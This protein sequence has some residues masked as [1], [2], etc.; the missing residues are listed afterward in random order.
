MSNENRG[1]Y[2]SLITK[3]KTVKPVKVRYYTRSDEKISFIDKKK[4]VK[5]IKVKLYGGRKNE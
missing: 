5:P 3:M 4:T 2:I 1:A